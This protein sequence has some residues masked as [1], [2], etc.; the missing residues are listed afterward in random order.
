MRADEYR[1]RARPAGKGPI[2][3]VLLA[4]TT[5][6]HTARRR[7]TKDHVHFPKI[8]KQRQRLIEGN[9]T[10]RGAAVHPRDHFPLCPITERRRFS[11][12]LL[13]QFPNR[14]NAT[15]LIASEWGATWMIILAAARQGHDRGAR[16]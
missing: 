11:V 2:Y 3:L 7:V 13:K 5:G 12:E 1:A 8:N 15:P 14:W 6:A 4:R 16:P 10:H 9:S